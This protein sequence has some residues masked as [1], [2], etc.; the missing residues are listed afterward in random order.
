MLPL[1]VLASQVG[2]AVAY[3]LVTPDGAER[4]HALATTGH[5]Y[6]AYAPAALAVCGVLV[7]LALVRE[8]GHATTYRKHTEPSLLP[9]AVLAPAIFASQEHIERLVHDG[10]FPFSAAL[11]TTFL[12]GLLLQLPFSAL[13]YFVARLL[14]NVVR[15]IGRRLSDPPRSRALARPMLRFAFRAT[16]PRVAVLALGYG[17]RGPPLFLR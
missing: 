6:L 15:S 7:A 14:L 13:A 17:S 4:G 8:L 3:R 1:A 9:F 12:V 16:R 10:A 2:H 5:G 11:D